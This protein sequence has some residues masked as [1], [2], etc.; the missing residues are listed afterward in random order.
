MDTRGCNSAD[1]SPETLM[2]VPIWT[3]EKPRESRYTLEKVT[4]QQ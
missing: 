4:T 2:R 1:S 3:L